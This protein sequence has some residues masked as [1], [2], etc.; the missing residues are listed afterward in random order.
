MQAIVTKYLGPTNNRCARV[1]ATAQAGSVTIS[2]DCALDVD[3]NH[4]AAAIALAVKR[5]GTIKGKRK[6]AIVK[7]FI[8]KVQSIRS[9][10]VFRYVEFPIRAVSE[11]AAI[12]LFWPGRVLA[13]RE[14][15]A[16]ENDSRKRVNQ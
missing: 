14:E 6:G 15:N 16:H 2:W 3:A 12:R 5:D 9:G 8:V 13:V 11:V 10:N 1:K 7:D 4:D